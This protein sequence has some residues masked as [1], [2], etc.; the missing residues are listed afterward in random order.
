MAADVVLRM[1]Y[2]KAKARLELCFGDVKNHFLAVDLLRSQH[3]ADSLEKTTEMLRENVKTLTDEF[4]REIET[5]KKLAEVHST[6]SME[7]CLTYLISYRCS[8]ES[9]RAKRY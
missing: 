2:E 4:R 8:L 7:T 1:A 3:R 6:I 5:L 9:Y